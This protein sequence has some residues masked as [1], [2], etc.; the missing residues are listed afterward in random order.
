MPHRHKHSRNIVVV[1]RQWPTWRRRPSTASPAAW[2]A[3]GAAVRRLHDAP[4]PPWPGRLH[5]ALL[6]PWPGRKLD[7]IAS[8]LDSE[9]TWLVTNGVLPADLVTR[10]R[11]VA[12][13]A[14][15]PS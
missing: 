13:A 2:A 15:R 1:P 10:N 6:V 3:A 14:L 7:D 5:D 4:L 8:Q 9:C 12:E 11:Q